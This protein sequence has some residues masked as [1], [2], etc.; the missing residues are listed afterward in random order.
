MKERKFM[1]I[2]LLLGI[3]VT[4]CSAA[5]F[6]GAAYESGDIVQSTYAP[7]AAMMEEMGVTSDSGRVSNAKMDMTISDT[8][9][10]RIVIKNAN[11][12]IVVVDPIEAVDS[13]GSM[14]ENLGGFVVFSNTYKTT[15]AS[16]IEVP[17]ANITIRV[18][19]QDLET[20]LAEIRDL[21]ENPDT[22]ILKE[23]ISGQDVTAEVTDLESRLRNLKQTE[24]KLL[25]ILDKAEE[26]ED[27]LSVFR[28]LTNIREQIEVLEG[29]IKYYRESARL[30]AISVNIQAQEAVA[31]IT[32]G[33][34][35]PAAEAQKALQALIDGVK[36]LVD[37][38]IW[39]V[40]LIIPLLLIIGAPIYLIAKFI[41]RRKKK[42]TEE[43]P[44]QDKK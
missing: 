33:G 24:Q 40:I 42:K 6:R 26:T 43:K 27:V 10:E 12:S 23:E 38:L 25:E 16:G 32:I 1:P 2:I 37:F 11:L 13:I 36:Y 41:Q 14:A 21:V 20:A 15:T 17:V 30:S 44:K 18:P 7:A 29:Q 3:L 34:W 8:N 28:E 4:S 19:A 22:D 39:L 5:L 9:S 31:P 35:Q